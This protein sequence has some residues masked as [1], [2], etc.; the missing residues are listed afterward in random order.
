MVAPAS[1]PTTL[2]LSLAS[3]MRH[4]GY[5]PRSTPRR[6]GTSRCTAT[7]DNDGLLSSPELTQGNLIVLCTGRQLGLGLHALLGIIDGGL[8]W[9]D[10]N[11]ILGL[12]SLASSLVVS[13]RVDSCRPVVST[14]RPAGGLLMAWD[15]HGGGELTSALAN[16]G[17]G[18]HER[19]SAVLAHVFFPLVLV[20]DVGALV[21]ALAGEAALFIL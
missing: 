20:N 15:G 16:I 13:G 17:N 6:R 11:T 10:L 1:T 19:P 12:Q 3:Q 21:G 2:G 14:V 9:V 18:F 7:H 4:M 5:V 8:D